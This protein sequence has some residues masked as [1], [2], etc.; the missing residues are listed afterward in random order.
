[1]EIFLI[2]AI[3]LLKGEIITFEYKSHGYLN[4]FHE[5]NYL[6]DIITHDILEEAFLKYNVIDD[7][8]FKFLQINKKKFMNLYSFIS[9]LKTEE[10]C[11]NTFKYYYKNKEVFGY[12]QFNPY[13]KYNEDELILICKNISKGINN[14]GI[15][16]AMESLIISIKSN[17]YEFKDDKFREDNLTSRIESSYFVS[18]QLQVEH[19]LNKVLVDVV[20]S[21]K[22]DNQIAKEKLTKYIIIF[23]VLIMTLILIILG[24]YLL[25]FPFKTLK[26]NDVINDVESCYY[27]TI[28]Y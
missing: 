20:I 25:F 19:I 5:L 23:Y 7:Y 15:N 16:T 27:N 24:F 9:K 8:I 12:N 13:N 21:W 3:I 28:I 11:D 26:E 6:N 10:A 4:I 22:I 14:K 2:Y 1:M 18:Y 17:F